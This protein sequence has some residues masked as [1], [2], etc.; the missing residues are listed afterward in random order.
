M[1]QSYIQPKIK[2]VSTICVYSM[3]AA[4]GPTETKKEKSYT[5]WIGSREGGGLFED[6]EEE[7]DSLW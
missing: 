1:K 6:E 4:S 5:K 7:E 3:L 2:I